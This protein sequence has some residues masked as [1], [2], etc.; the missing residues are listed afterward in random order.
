MWLAT[1]P[2]PIRSRRLLKDDRKL[3]QHVLEGLMYVGAADGAPFASTEDAFLKTVAG[4]F[5]FSDSE[6]RFFR[7]RFVK[8]HGNPYD[9][10]RLA[11]ED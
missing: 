11:P 4:Q 8:D 7:A 3:L 1:R 2:M 9:A 6:F 5:G 10:L